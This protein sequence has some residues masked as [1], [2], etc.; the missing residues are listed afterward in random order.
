MTMRSEL[1]ESPCESN[2]VALGNCA[3]AHAWMG[4]TELAIDRA[5]RA[6]DLSPIDSLIAHMAIAVAELQAGVSSK[7]TE[8]RGAL[9]PMLSS[10]PSM[11][12]RRFCDPALQLAPDRTFDRVNYVRERKF[13]IDI[14]DAAAREFEPVQIQNALANDRRIHIG[15]A[16]RGS[17]GCHLELDDQIGRHSV[18]QFVGAR[19]QPPNKAWNTIQARQQR[20]VVEC[21]NLTLWISIRDDDKPAVGRPPCLDELLVLVLGDCKSPAG[22]E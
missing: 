19:F 11:I 12:M 16:L 21:E 10:R 2:V 1:S 14:D 6:L 4:E 18:R 17:L 9:A 7:H 20:A 13:G 15:L 5:K 3:F 22:Q 8:P